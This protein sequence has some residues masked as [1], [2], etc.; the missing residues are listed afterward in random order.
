M[1][2]NIRHFVIPMMITAIFFTVAALPV[3]TLGCRNRGLIAVGIAL[4]AGIM[5]IVA[6]VRAVLNKIRG[7]TK[8]SMWMASALI[9][10]IPA[11]YIVVGEG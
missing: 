6:A 8:T 4:V 1:K 3:E 11:I 2:K 10:A 5:G 7:E 9:L